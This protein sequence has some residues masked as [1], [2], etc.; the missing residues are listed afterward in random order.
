MVRAITCWFGLVYEA[1]P[2]MKCTELQTCLLKEFSAFGVIRKL[3]VPSFIWGM[4]AWCAP[5]SGWVAGQNVRLLG[6][7]P[8]LP[9]NITLKYLSVGKYSR[10]FI[11]QIAQISLFQRRYD[12]LLSSEKWPS[13]RQKGSANPSFWLSHSVLLPCLL[14]NHPFSNLDF[15]GLFQNI[16]LKLVLLSHDTLNLTTH[17][18]F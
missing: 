7:I 1:C 8:G 2:T 13:Y 10:F 17:C 5:K 9:K 3:Y 4:M 6:L 15:T 18:L 16:F 12:S 11:Q 14:P